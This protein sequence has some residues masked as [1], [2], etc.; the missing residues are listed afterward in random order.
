VTLV[1]IKRRHRRFA[2]TVEMPADALLGSAFSQAINSAKSF[3]GIVFQRTY[4]DFNNFTPTQKN[5]SGCVYFSM[6]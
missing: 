5:Q 3:A 1:C 4:G 2:P 6:L